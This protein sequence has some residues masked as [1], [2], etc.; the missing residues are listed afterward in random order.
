[1]FLAHGPLGYITN[2]LIQ[3]KAISELKSH[4]QVIVAV[5]ALLFG[6]LPDIDLLIL[7]MFNIPPFAHHNYF[8]HT[9][10]FY[11][12]IWLIL[13]LI[14]Y[15]FPKILNKKT[16]GVLHLNLLNIL[17]NT[18]LICTMVHFLGDIIVG[19]IMIFYPFSTVHISIFE[20]ILEP[21]N[22]VSYFFLPYFSIEI[23]ICAIFFAMIYK[24]FFRKNTLFEI[25]KYALLVI[26]AAFF[27][28]TTFFQFKTYN[29]SYLYDSNGE[30]IYDTDYDG[31]EDSDD[32][33][34]DND[35]KGNIIDIELDKLV[36][37]VKNILNSRKLASYNKNSVEF[38]LGGFDSY[39]VISQAY[40]NLHS[41]IE[42]VLRNHSQKPGYEKGL[43]YTEL[44]YK[45][46]NDSG[47]LKEISLG[48]DI[49]NSKG[50]IFFLFDK[51]NNILN[52]GI[53]LDDGN[54][55]IVLKDEK[56]LQIHKPEEIA[57]ENVSKVLITI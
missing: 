23:L 26:S 11:I 20:D 21:N 36:T 35:W 43:D 16:S 5:S 40:F 39:R 7:Q 9:P 8:T 30:Q 55:G 4:D 41:P 57:I 6:I 19:S 27:I 18:F 50:S 24:K 46:F 38:L 44:L 29:K 56:H 53:V 47:L 28:V 10:I 49:T 31:L 3:K 34:V 14:V 37:E 22:F 45:Y 54:I 13:K 51:D 12:G 32:L 17:L 15:V 33:D 1:M 52:L 48:E 25:F 42:P 2:E